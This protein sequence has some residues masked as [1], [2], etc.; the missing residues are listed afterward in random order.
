MTRKK[1]SPSAF[2]VRSSAA[3]YLTFVAASGGGGVEAVYAVHGQTAAEV[4]KGR[5]DHRKDHM[6]LTS[7]QGTP[8]GKIHRYD[9]VVDKIYLSAFELDLIQRIVS[10]YFDMAEMQTRRH[11]PMTMQDCEQRLAGFLRLW[12]REILQDAGR[13]TAELA[14]AQ[15]ESEFEKFRIVQDRLF[16]SEFDRRLTTTKE[17]GEGAKP[18]RPRGKGDRK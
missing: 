12:G 5:A 10:A 11:I 3:E 6:G 18:K 13:V 8:A 9:V 16:E 14:K 17:L 15:A 2:L 4:T 1:K 7:W